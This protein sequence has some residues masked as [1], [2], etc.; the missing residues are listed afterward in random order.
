M[1]FLAVWTFLK[2]IFKAIPWWGWAALGL[3]VAFFV[4]GE[5]RYR[6]GQAERQGLWDAATTAQANEDR[7]NEAKQAEITVQRVTEYVDRVKTVYVKGDTIIKR[8]PV[9][10]P[11]DTPDLPGGWRLLHDAAV[12]GAEL[13]ETPGSLQAFPVS[14]QDAARTVAANYTACKAELEKL[15]GLWLWSWDQATKVG[16]PVSGS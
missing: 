6:A 4:Y 7:K 5:S 2:G 15:N 8:V 10:V 11:A 13:P 1:T 3:A 9:Y 16:H 12:T 14:A